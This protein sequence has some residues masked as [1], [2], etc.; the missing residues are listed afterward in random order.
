MP[1]HWHLVLRP[2]GDGDLSN[3]MRWLTV[4][5]TQRWHAH[6]HTGGTGHLYQGRRLRAGGRSARTHIAAGQ[7]RRWDWIQLFDREDDRGRLRT[8]WRSKKIPDPFIPA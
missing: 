2:A 7:A 4:T 3:F 6:H 1:N 5:H 8:R